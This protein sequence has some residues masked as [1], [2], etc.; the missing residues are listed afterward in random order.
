[1]N[2]IKSDFIKED[3]MMQMQENENKINRIEKILNNNN[4]NGKKNIMKRLEPSVSSPY[5]N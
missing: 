1:M 2:N 5:N 3:F 4:N